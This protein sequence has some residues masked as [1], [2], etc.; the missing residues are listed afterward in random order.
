[1]VEF[2][3]GMIEF[4]G[5]VWLGMVESRCGDLVWLSRG[6]VIWNRRVEYRLSAGLVWLSTVRWWFDMVEFSRYVVV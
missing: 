6:V 2:N 1:M 3:G 4:S 5:G